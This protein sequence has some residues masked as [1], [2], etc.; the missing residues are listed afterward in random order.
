MAGVDFDTALS[1]LGAL[2]A[3]GFVERCDRGWRLGRP[4]KESVTN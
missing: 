1:C 4:E 3:A 2:A